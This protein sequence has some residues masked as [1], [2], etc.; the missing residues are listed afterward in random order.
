MTRSRDRQRRPGGA[1][2]PRAAHRPTWRGGTKVLWASYPA[3]GAQTQQLIRE[4]ETGGAIVSVDQQA[5]KGTKT[6]I[7]QFLIPILLLVCLFS[8][9]MRLGTEGAAGGIAGFSQFAGKGKKKGKG[10]SDR[11]TFSDVA[12][13]GEAV[14]ELR[15][16]RDYLAEPQKYLSVGAAAPEG[17]AAGGPPRHRQDAARQGG[18]RRSRRGLLLAVGLGLRRVAR[19]RRCGARARPLPQGAQ[20]GARD[21][22]HRRARRRR[23]QARRR[24]RAG[25]RRARADAQ[26]DPRRDGRLRRRRRPGGDGRDQPARHP[27]PG[28]AAPRALRP[29]DRD[30]RPRR[31]RAPGDPAPARRQAPARARRL[32][33]RG[34]APDARLQRRRARQRDQ[35]GGPAERP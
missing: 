25:Q 22:L 15:E 5:G 18:R 1:P 13:A 20:G 30:R 12:G 19:R 34:R 28:A 16:I 29:P 17:R 31:A 11:I 8:L 3:S 24:H 9:F 6:I 35:R 33:G 10:T 14:A 2:P 27:R 21:H 7:V 32:A 26:P 23:A 4:L